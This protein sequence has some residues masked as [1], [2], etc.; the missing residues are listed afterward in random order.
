MSV[1]QKL[2]SMLF[3]RAAPQD[4]PYDKSLMVRLTF[5][6]WFSGVLVLSA[7]LQ[8]DDVLQS[9]LLSVVVL[10]V[11]VY[12]ILRVFNRQAR[13]V[14]TFS[15][16]AGVSLLFNLASWPMLAV[17]AGASE[18]D[19]LLTTMS[20]VFLML[21]SWEVLVKAYIFRHAIDI[22][23][24]NAM[25]LSFA[26]FFI[27]MT[28]SQLLFSTDAGEQAVGGQARRNEPAISPQ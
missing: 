17:V 10:L 26:L 14:Q 16:V 20:F 7:T 12:G 15:A 2:L 3:L 28:L 9:M 21:I 19:P 6:Y 11:F 24:L 22:S 4:L 1:L 8:P 18:G 25:L 27:A 13:F 23:M 5:L